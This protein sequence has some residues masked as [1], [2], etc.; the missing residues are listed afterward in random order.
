MNL[1]S[2]DSEQEATDSGSE[3]EEDEDSD[4]DGDEDLLPVEKAA[5]KLKRTQKKEK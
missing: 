4:E 5:K 1:D 3:N 2:T